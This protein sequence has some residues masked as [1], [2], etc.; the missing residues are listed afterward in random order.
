[1]PLFLKRHICD[2]ALLQ[3]ETAVGSGVFVKHCDIAPG[4]VKDDDFLN[5]MVVG[6]AG[7]ACHGR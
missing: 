3:V 1:V 4:T 6:F 7:T 2:G 5:D